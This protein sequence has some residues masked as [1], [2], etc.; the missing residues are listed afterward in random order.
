M[1]LAIYCAGGMGREVLDLARSVNRWE[2]IIFVDDVT[3]QKVCNGTPVYRF[4]DIAEFK[5]NIEFVIANGEPAARHLLYEKIK[6][7]QYTLT[8]IISDDCDISSSSS[9]GDGCIIF[10]SRIS[11][12]VCV[13]DNVIIEFGVDLGHDVVVK[14]HVVLNSLSFVGG[15]THIGERTYIAPGSLLRD[16]IFVGKDAI[17]GLGSVVI[18]DVADES[19]VAGNPAKRMGDNME[20]KV[21]R[22]GEIS[23]TGGAN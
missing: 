18:H 17:V 22:H 13:G 14:N 21:F 23:Q 2:R 19:I 15:Y 12:N 3:P 10:Q 16:R 6:Q 4:S 7:S 8:T 5:E 11:P 9:I 1:I 20:R